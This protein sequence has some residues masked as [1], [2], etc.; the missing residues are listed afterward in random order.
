MNTATTLSVILAAA[1]NG[2]IGRAQQLPWRLSRDLQ[3]FKQLT[4]GAPLIMGRLTFQSLG[5]FLP[6]RQ[7]LVISRQVE[8]QDWWPATTKPEQGL[9]FPSFAD[10]WEYGSRTNAASVFAIGGHSVFAAAL[11]LADRLFFTRVLA[12]VA[13]DVQM[14]PIHW[15]QWE[16][17][18]KEHHPADDRNE[19]DFVFEDYR[20]S[21]G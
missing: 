9:I 16:L 13:G 8:N 14:P 4:M 19:Y 7:H 11:P 17:I 12:E 15:D 21:L 5:R 20:R 10:A 2:V 3:R 1:Q 18:A 6:G